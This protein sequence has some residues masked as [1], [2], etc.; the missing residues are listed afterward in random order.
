MEGTTPVDA[1]GPEEP[2]PFGRPPESLPRHLPPP[3]TRAAGRGDV[4]DAIQRGD[5]D[6]IAPLRLERMRFLDPA[7]NPAFA[8]LEVLT[9]VATRGGRLAGRIT[10]HV[11]R[12]YDAY[13]G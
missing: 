6:Y 5:P 10:A 3:P 12:A 9:L 7:R 1:A 11:D 4:A 13:H 2:S 8:Q